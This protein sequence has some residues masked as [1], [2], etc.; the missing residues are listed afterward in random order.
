MPTWYY[1]TRPSHLAFHDFTKTKKPPKNLRSLLGLGLKFI[2]TPRYT[3]KWSRLQLTTMD[4][5]RRSMYLRFYFATDNDDDP[6]DDTYNPKMYVP[7]NWSPPYWTFPKRIVD[8]RLNAFADQMKKIFKLRRGRTNLLPHQHRALQSLQQQRDFLIVPCDKNL[9]PAI[10]QTEDYL[11]IAFRDHLND[12]TT[13]KCLSKRESDTIQAQLKR[14]VTEWRDKHKKCCTKMEKK[15]LRKQQESNQNP[16]ARFFLTLKAHKLKPGQHVDHLKSRPIVSCPGSLL[17]PIGVWVDRYLQQVSV[18][19]RSFFRNSFDLKQHLVT[20]SLPPNARLFTSDAVS[21]YTNIPT[22]TALPTIGRLLRRHRATVDRNFP[23]DAVMDGLGLIMR[24]NVFTIGDATFKQLN[25]TAM[26]T[27]PAPPYAT[28]Y[29]AAHEDGLL[30]RWNH[31]LLLYKRFIDDVFGIWLSDND[32]ETDRQQ[33]LA[34]QADMNTAR[35]LDWEFSELSLSVDFMDLTISINHQRI[36]TT[37]FE[38]P[39]NLH[40]YIPPHSA[41]PPGLLPGIVFGT[42]FRIYTLCSNDNDRIDRTRIFFKRLIARGY[43]ADKIRPLFYRAIARAQTYTGPADNTDSKDTSSIILHLPFHPN[44]PAS[45]EIQRSWNDYIAK[46]P[47][48][49]PIWNLANKK[50]VKCGVKRMIIAYKR[51]MNLGNLLSHRNLDDIGPP[52]SSYLDTD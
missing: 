36:S 17:H 24:N 49:M 46:P 6:P 31:K 35:G 13:Y 2:P 19:Q 43:K 41:H 44:D 9:G 22:N 20:L 48:K 12:R 37:L 5:F 23:T 38:K 16:F 32:P 3:N 39:M 25:G 47:Y 18:R 30:H 50:R 1:F 7:S 11:K 34:F 15:Y 4:R 33:W 26:G 52:V 51:P 21:M 42:L 27:P 8:E 29:Y 40:L 14:A 28:L 45:Y 10:I